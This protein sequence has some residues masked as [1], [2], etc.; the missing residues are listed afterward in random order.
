MPCLYK[1]DL[2][3]HYKCSRTTN[4]VL[5][6]A[7]EMGYLSSRGFTTQSEGLYQNG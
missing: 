4:I 5:I 1:P 7:D 3:K 2:L 6:M